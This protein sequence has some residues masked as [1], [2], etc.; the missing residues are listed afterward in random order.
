MISLDVAAKWF[1]IIDCTQSDVTRWLKI[2]SDVFE[3]GVAMKTVVSLLA[4]GSPGRFRRPR[5][6][7]A[8]APLL[9]PF[10]PPV[11]PGRVLQ[12]A[13]MTNPNR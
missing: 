9:L 2:T 13:D 1:P 4:L 11:T 8:P 10:G 3:E 7:S 5:A 12:T 6:Q